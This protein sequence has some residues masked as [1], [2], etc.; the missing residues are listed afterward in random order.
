M[1]KKI[2]SIR[3]SFKTLATDSHQLYDSVYMQR[4]CYAFVNTIDLD[5]QTS[6]QTIELF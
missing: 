2:I 3:H 1:P 6:G 4:L 5:A